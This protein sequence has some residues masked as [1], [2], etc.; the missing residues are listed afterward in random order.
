MTTPTVTGPEVWAAML[1]DPA[2]AA[3]VPEGSEVRRVVQECT[4]KAP[5]VLATLLGERVT[6][7]VLVNAKLTFMRYLLDSGFISKMAEASGMGDDRLIYT[8]ERLVEEF[9]MIFEDVPGILQ[10]AGVTEE[11]VMLHPQVG[12]TV[13]NQD[14]WRAGTLTVADL[15]RTQPLV[16]LRK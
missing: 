7:K 8:L 10:A 11:Q 2:F 14:A 16:I 9:A 3:Q 1:V 6:F 4:E 12:L 15:L 5:K 13:V